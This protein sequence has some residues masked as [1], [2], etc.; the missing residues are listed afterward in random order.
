M[1]KW[2]I[3]HGVLGLCVLGVIHSLTKIALALPPEVSVF[4]RLPDYKKLKLWQL[5]LIGVGLC[6]AMSGVLYV[7]SLTIV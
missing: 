1:E 4:Y 3:L 7:V 2:A 5:I 6:A